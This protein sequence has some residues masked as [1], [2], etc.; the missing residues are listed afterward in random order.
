MGLQTDYEQMEQR[1][2]IG[3]QLKAIG[4]R[5]GIRFDGQRQS[6]GNS[7]RCMIQNVRRSE[8]LL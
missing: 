4:P 2:A 1:R 7:S 8:S 3:E 6:G 5:A